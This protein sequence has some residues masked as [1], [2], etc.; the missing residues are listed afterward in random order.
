[1][2]FFAEL[3]VRA[4]DSPPV[5]DAA[6]RTVLRALRRLAVVVAF[7]E[8]LTAVV[9]RALPRAELERDVA[10]CGSPCLTVAHPA[11]LVDQ[12]LTSPNLDRPFAPA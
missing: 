6:A 4:R 5:D 3:L 2:T 10:I 12:R 7:F 9:L 1:M 8:R 11:D